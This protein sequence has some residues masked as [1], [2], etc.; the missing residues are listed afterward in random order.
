MHGLIINCVPLIK[1]AY[2]YAGNLRKHKLWESSLS[3][4]WT[5]AICDL[6][7]Q[8]ISQVGDN[9]SDMDLMASDKNL[10][11]PGYEVVNDHWMDGWEIIQ[12][13]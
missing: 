6:T 8:N 1:L 7:S 11:P 9:L 13:L 10:L 3:H 4:N 12:I 5:L 2:T